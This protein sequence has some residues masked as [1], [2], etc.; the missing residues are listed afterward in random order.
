MCEVWCKVFPHQV[1][2]RH[3]TGFPTYKLS[4]G[5]TDL[6]LDCCS[7]HSLAHRQ[8]TSLRQVKTSRFCWQLGK[9]KMIKGKNWGSLVTASE[10]EFLPC[11][12]SPLENWSCIALYDLQR[13]GGWLVRYKHPPIALHDGGCCYKQPPSPQRKDWDEMEPTRKHCWS[14]FWTVDLWRWMQ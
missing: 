1:F 5:K 4:L 7:S 2:Y 9:I 14:N 13:V 11:L 10:R 3:K 6:V 8:K 12:S